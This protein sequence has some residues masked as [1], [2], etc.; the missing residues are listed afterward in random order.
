MEWTPENRLKIISALAAQALDGFKGETRL[1][2]LQR[3][4]FLCDMPDEFLE[5]NKRNFEDAIER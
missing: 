3:I 1:M 5:E 2:F 4:M